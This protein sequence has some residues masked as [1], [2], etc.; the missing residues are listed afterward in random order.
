MEPKSPTTEDDG[1]APV[2]ATVLAGSGVGLMFAPVRRS[3]TARL[4]SLAPASDGEEG[5]TVAEL[6]G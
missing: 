4:P 3:K 6:A 5:R 1:V 2:V